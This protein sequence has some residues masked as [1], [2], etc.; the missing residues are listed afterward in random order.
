MH[1]QRLHRC[2][3]EIARSRNGNVTVSLVAMK[4]AKALACVIFCAV[5]LAGARHATWTIAIYADALLDTR[6]GRTVRDAVVVVS[7]DRIAYVGTTLGLRRELSD[8]CLHQP[9]N[10][11]GWGGRFDRLSPPV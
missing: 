3:S 11:C 8:P 4:L 5:L 6:Q 2:Q 10:E 1:S 9:A 7:D